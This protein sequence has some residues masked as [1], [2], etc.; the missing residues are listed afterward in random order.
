VG[1]CNILEVWRMAP[2]FLMWCIWRERNS[3][4]IEDFKIS[5]A[6]LKSVMLKSLYAWMVVY[7][8]PHFSTFTKKIVP[9]LPYRGSLLYTNCAPMCFLMKLIYF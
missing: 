7:G 4:S 1:S 9:F 2:L 8:S 6:E 5:V 3:R